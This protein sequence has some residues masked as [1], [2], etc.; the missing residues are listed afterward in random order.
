MDY[1]TKWAEAG[2]LCSKTAVEVAQFLA[3]LFFRHGLPAIIMSDQGREFVN[4]LH[5]ELFLVSGVRHMVSTAYHPQT[6]GLIE[7][8]N[9]TLQRSLLKMVGEN[10]DEWYKY[11]DSVVFAYNSSMQSSTKYSPFFLLYGRDPRL[12]VDLLTKP[13][14]CA[15]CIHF[16]TLL[17]HTAQNVF[18]FEVF[19]SCDS[20]ESW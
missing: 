9:Q 5:D 16:I 14:G 7:K 10:Q 1:Y 6:N 11:L 13:E 4:R 20:S 15:K 12:P 18:K 17:Y 8:F 3:G 2:A 19:G